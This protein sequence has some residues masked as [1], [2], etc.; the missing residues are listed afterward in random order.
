V[1]AAFRPLVAGT[2]LATSY[3]PV[4]LYETYSGSL[5]YRAIGNSLRTQ[6]STTTLTVDPVVD[7]AMVNFTTGTTATLTLPMN[8]NVEAA[9]LYWA[10]SGKTADIVSE[11]R[12]GPDGNEV[13]VVAEE[14]FQ[15]VGTTS[16][17]VDFFAGY[18]DVTNIVAGSGLYRLKDLVVQTTT[19][20]TTNGTCAGGWSLITIYSDPDEHLRVVNLFHGFQPFQYSAFTLVPRNF[21]MATYDAAQ[22]LPNGQVTHVTLE[23]DEQLANGE[24]TLGMQKGPTGLD[25]TIFVPLVTSFNPSNAEFNSTITRPIYWLGPTGYMEFESNAGINGDGYEIDFPG[26]DAV[27]LNRN[28]N[29]IGS[30][31]GFDVDTHYLSHTLLEDF[32]QFGSEA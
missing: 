6:P 3:V 22:L 12:F 10:G 2:P 32:A 16:S 17:N 7:C 13:A 1:V 11:V 30:T 14:I 24:E 26:P 15:A 21:R 23:G 8:A 27:Q 28:G 19:P 5:S 9:F 25:S 20:W 4:T 29:R 31:W 18:A